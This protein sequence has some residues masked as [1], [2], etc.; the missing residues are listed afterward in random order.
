AL[1]T[2][3]PELIAIA[4]QARIV[5]RVDVTVGDVVYN[6]YHVLV[7]CQLG[8]REILLK[9]P[10]AGFGKYDVRAGATLAIGWQAAASRVFAA[11]AG[12][13]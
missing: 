11:P 9:A 8:P 3:R 5:N 4:P 10:S 7:P 13:A 2:L 12:E 1:I 6:G